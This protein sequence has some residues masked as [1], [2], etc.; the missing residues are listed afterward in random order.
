MPLPGP[1]QVRIRGLPQR[2]APGPA[3][4]IDPRSAPTGSGL[5]FSG[6]LEDTLPPA[7]VE[8][9]LAVLR[10]ALGDVARHP[11]ARSVEIDVTSTGAG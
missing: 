3:A 10:D 7:V 4:P 6:L 8:D 1:G 11:G 5:R 2:T 9:L